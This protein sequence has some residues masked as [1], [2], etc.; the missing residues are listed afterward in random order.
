M[1]AT[2][3]GPWRVPASVQASAAAA[4]AAEDEGARAAGVVADG[5]AT[6]VG[7]WWCPV[8]VRAPPCAA[9]A[10]EGGVVE[11]SFAAVEAEES[12]GVEA[13]A[14]VLELCNDDFALHQWRVFERTGGVL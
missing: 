9:A 1:E 8:L 4:E 12:V 10:A 11:A 2:G 14:T 3:D 7:P 6:G 5:V 13:V